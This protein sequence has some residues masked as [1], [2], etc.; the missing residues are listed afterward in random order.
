MERDQS[1]LRMTHKQPKFWQFACAYILI[2]A[3]SIMVAL[4]LLELALLGDKK[5]LLTGLISIWFGV[6]SLGI[7]A[8]SARARDREEPTQVDRK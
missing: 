3:G 4:Q 6:F 5:D 2:G 7:L 8:R 1:P